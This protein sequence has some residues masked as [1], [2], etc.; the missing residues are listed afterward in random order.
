MCSIHVISWNINGLNGQFKYTASLD[1]LHR[2]RVDVA[3]IQESHLRSIDINRF[4][5]KHHYVAASLDTK[6]RGSLVVLKCN[7]PITVMEKYGGDDGRVSYIKTVIAGRN[8]AFIS[9]YAPSQY[10]SEF[11]PNLTATL[12][13]LQDFS[14]ILGA[15]MNCF[16]Y[17]TLDKSVQRL[18]H[19]QSRASTDFQKFLSALVLTDLYHA[20]NP[21][22]KQIDYIL[23]S[24]AS[25]SEIHDVLIKPCSLSDHNSGNK[26]L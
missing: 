11:F 12:L 15:D 2:Q 1:L 8:F 23:A 7:L 9:V 6:T 26:Y 4:T 24:P 10:E 25:F 16:A 5:N 18:T 3:F 19:N 13:Q 20:V 14:L 17:M 22:S 21:T